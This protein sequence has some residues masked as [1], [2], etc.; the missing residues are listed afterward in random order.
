MLLI[1]NQQVTED[2]FIKKVEEISGKKI[3]IAEL[4]QN[5]EFQYNNVKDAYDLGVFKQTGNKVYKEKR[6]DDILAGFNVYDKNAGQTVQFRYASRNPY[7]NPKN[8]NVLVYE[9]KAID[10]PA[11]VFSYGADR[12]TE[13]AIYFYCYPDCEQSPFHDPSKAYKYSHNNLKEASNK[14]KKEVDQKVLALSHV[15]TLD[16]HELVPMAKGLGIFIASNSD[17]DDVKVLLQE[18]ALAN[19]SK[20]M[21]KAGNETV[22]FDGMVQDAIDIGFVVKE[23]QGSGIVWKFAKGRK[24]GQPILS[25]PSDVQDPI[26][27]LKSFLKTNIAKYYHDFATM[28]RDLTAD[29]GAEEFLRAQKAGMNREHVAPHDPSL[30]L[31]SVVDHSSA[32]E[33]LKNQHPEKGNP[34]Q[35]NTATFLQAV[36]SGI[37]NDENLAEE[38]VKYINKS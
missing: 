18:Y 3:P 20:Y 22:K 8:V 14:K 38:V 1:N 26:E 9:P 15:S 7:P 4:K 25:V 36:Q 28:N 10:F 33:F 23:H 32:K 21:E 31:S 11:A 16:E 19:A 17:A 13:L 34:S 6:S 29:L 12:E 37:I 27:E 24:N 2:V 5:K 35:T 30:E